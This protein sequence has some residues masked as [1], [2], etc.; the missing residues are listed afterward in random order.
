MRTVFDPAR[1]ESGL[2]DRYI[3]TAF[4]IVKHVADNLAY[5]KQTSFYMES[6]V[7]IDN[8]MDKLQA[9]YVEL[10]KLLVIY[11][12]LPMLR[13]L[14]EDVAE[15]MTALNNYKELLSAD[16][17]ATHIGASGGVTVQQALDAAAQ[18]LDTLEE[19]WNTYKDTF[20]NLQSN[21]MYRAAS[22]AAGVVLAQKLKNGELVLVS[23][24]ETLADASALYVVGGGSTKTLSLVLNFD[25]VRVDLAKVTGAA[26][27][28]TTQNKTVQDFLT[29]LY[30]QG[31]YFAA[32]KAAATAFQPSLKDGSLIVVLADESLASATVLYKTTTGGLSLVWNLNALKVALADVAQG[33]GLVGH[34]N[35][36][37]RPR[38]SR[39]C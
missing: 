38:L 11:D 37:P 16:G 1:N 31:A 4:D 2:V 36:D 17:G 19:N 25:Q 8:N 6:L 27:V 18:R 35:T 14:M 24:D 5:I 13:T 26:M 33:S 21:A 34:T 3:G 29:D 23:H 22:N 30:N 15:Y 7:N 32:T 39:R 10:A 28:K 20:A 12:N 9:I